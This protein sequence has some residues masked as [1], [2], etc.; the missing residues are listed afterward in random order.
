MGRFFSSRERTA[1]YLAAD[2]C[3]VRCGD[4]LEPGWHADHVDPHARGG[5]TDV[6]NGQALCPACNLKKGSTPVAYRDTFAPRPFQREVVANVLDAMSSGRRT[7]IVLA[8]PGSGKTLAYQATANYLHRE[9]LIDFVAV[10]VPRLVLAKQC[11]TDW[12]TRTPDDR[13]VGDHRLFDT[14]NRLGQIRH[15]PTRLPLTPPGAFGIGFVTTYSSLVSQSAVFLDGWAVP[16]H[17]R[18]LLV[19]DEAQFCGASNDEQ[20]GGTQAGVLMERLHQHSAHTLLLTGTPYRSDGQPLILAE[21]DE[22]DE[23]GRRRLLSHVEVGYR[24]GIAEGYLR[25]FEATLH[26]ARI[27]WRG[28]DNTAIEYDLSMSGA[29]LREVLRKPEVWRPIAD[30]V[31]AMVKEKQQVNAQYRGLISCM[32]QGEARAVERYLK[33]TYAGLR[34]MLAV[35]DDGPQAEQALRD[36]KV[37]PADVLVT[38][39]KAFIGYDCKTITVVGI[40]THYRDRGHLMQLVGRGLRMWGETESRRQSCLVVTTDDPAMQE[41]IE[42]MRTESAD[43]LREREI[44]EARSREEAPKKTVEELGAVETAYATTH[45]AVSNDVEIE[46]SELLLIEAIKHEH[47]LV[48]DVTK[49]AKLLESYGA[50]VPAAA[51][52]V[53][54][55][56]VETPLSEEEHIKQV[57]SLTAEAIG[58]Y[59]SSMGAHPKVV[60]Y[61]R[62]RERMTAAVNTEAGV[63]AGNVWTLDDAKRRLDAVANLARR[64]YVP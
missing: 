42:F 45:R 20:E 62:I 7:T 4:E 35:S 52:V 58:Q 22:P 31:V 8:G 60:G 19:A 53:P 16:N 37:Q 38:V 50:R 54:A 46:Y 15:T 56:R 9:G 25:P 41:F 27:R 29:D 44:R 51:E 17:G 28:V 59:L 13:I 3:C 32:E 14:Q 43:G 11:E 40:L 63:A 64:G 1:L 36:F 57:K 49:L 6:I 26:E 18:F 2:G 39:R 47:G 34:V 48:D 30:Q 23:A 24:E 61:A 21:Y 55:V 10:F 5:V 12:W 33:S